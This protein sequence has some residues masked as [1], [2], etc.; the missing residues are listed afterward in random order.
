MVT[1]NS[2]EKWLCTNYHLPPGSPSSVAITRFLAVQWSLV[3]GL[4]S[5]IICS[6]SQS[7]KAEVN[8]VESAFIGG[9]ITKLYGLA[10]LRLSAAK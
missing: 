2:D 1:N 5:A 7:Q 10:D 3:S 9:E 8:A 6:G 4:R